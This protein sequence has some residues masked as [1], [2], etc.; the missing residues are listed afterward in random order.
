MRVG[1]NVGSG[2][3]P[4]IDTPSVVWTNV[5]SQAKWGPDIVCDGAHITEADDECADYFVLHHVLEHFGCG[6]GIDLLKEAH[7][8]LRP[9]GSL[10]VFVPDLRALAQRWM[11]GDLSTQVYMTN[12]YGAFMGNEDDRHKW[13][14]DSLYLMQFLCSVT[15][16]EVKYFNWRRIPGADIAKDWWIIGI[17]CVK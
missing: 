8:L 11:A 3:R 17:E 16:S 2:Q 14:Y 1:F 12:I 7:R 13:G 5:D 15:W 9:G 10:L 6:E 4:F